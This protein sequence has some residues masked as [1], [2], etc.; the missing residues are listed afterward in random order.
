MIGNPTLFRNGNI[1]AAQ[2]QWEVA[3]ALIVL[4]TGIL[5]APLV[6]EEFIPRLDPDVRLIN[7]EAVD[8]GSLS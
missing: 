6:A 5:S 2:Q 1:P 4:R 7:K 8:A 3:Q